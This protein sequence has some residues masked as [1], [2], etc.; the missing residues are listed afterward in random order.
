MESQ[1]HGEIIPFRNFKSVFDYTLSLQE[2]EY[3][4]NASFSKVVQCET[5][6]ACSDRVWVRLMLVLGLSTVV[7]QNIK[8]IIPDCCSLPYKLLWGSVVTPQ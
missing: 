3:P 7:N 2:A 4:Y 5:I 6:R 8:I 1:N